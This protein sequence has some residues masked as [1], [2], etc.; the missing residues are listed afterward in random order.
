M[1]LISLESIGRG[2]SKVYTQFDAKNNRHLKGIGRL[3]GE[4]TLSK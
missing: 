1:G 3:S 4:V 2:V